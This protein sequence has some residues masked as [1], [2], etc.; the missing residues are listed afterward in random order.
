MPSSPITTRLAKETIEKL[1]KLS[2][3][4]Q[5]SKSFLVAE[6]VDKY[7]SDQEW[8]VKAIKKGLEQAEKREF[9]SDDDVRDFFRKRGIA[10]ED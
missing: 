8:Q 9:A 7:L 5:R 2:Q 6:A 4:T 1:E 10:V 3:A